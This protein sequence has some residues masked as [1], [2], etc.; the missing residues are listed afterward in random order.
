MALNR[1]SGHC[2]HFWE[3]RY[4]ATTII[5]K[6]HRRVLN[7]LRY[8]H[9]NPKA[10]GVRKGIYDPYSNYGHYG[11]LECDGISEWNPSFLTLASTLK[12]CSTR[13]QDFCKQYRHHAKGAPK[14]HW[15]SRILK[16]L[17]ETSC[18]SSRSRSRSKNK[19]VS[20]GRLHLL[21]AFDLRLHRIPDDW[22]QVAVRFRRANGIRDGDNKRSTW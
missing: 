4:Y 5:P 13:Y 3:A 15:G 18:S 14:C 1:L 9:A 8:I 19:R 10:P 16:R 7:T 22:H 6:D 12:G 2:G 20:L 11:R 21:F 17:V